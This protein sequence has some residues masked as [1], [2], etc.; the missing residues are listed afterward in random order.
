MSTFDTGLRKDEMLPS[1]I[2]GLAGRHW[3]NEASFIGTCYSI[4]L[5]VV[6]F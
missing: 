6:K 1:L 2:I 3:L 5:F 4:K